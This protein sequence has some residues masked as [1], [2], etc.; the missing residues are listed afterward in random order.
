MKVWHSKELFSRSKIWDDLSDLYENEAEQAWQSVGVPFY[1]TSTPLHAKA[2]AKTT[3]DYFLEQ[4]QKSFSN[5]SSDKFSD[6]SLEWN[7]L[8]WG[9]G[10]G[11]F[12]YLFLKFFEEIFNNYFAGYEQF[13]AVTSIAIPKWRYVMIDISPKLQK[14]WLNHPL[15]KK[16]FS[17]G[18]LDF[19][20]FDLRRDK[21]LFLHQSQQML[22]SERPIKGIVV[23]IANYFFDSLEAEAYIIKNK[24]VF[25][26]L[27][28]AFTQESSPK[29]FSSAVSSMNYHFEAIEEGN[30]FNHAFKQAEG[31]DD[32]FEYYLHH[33]PEDQQFSLPSGASQVCSLIERFTSQGFLLLASDQGFGDLDALEQNLKLELGLHGSIS[34]PVNFHGLSKLLKAQ[35]HSVKLSQ[36]SSHKF[37]TMAA[38]ISKAQEAIGAQNKIQ[39]RLDGFDNENYWRL[40]NQLDLE[41]NQ[42]LSKLYLILKLGDWDPI[43]FF[44]YIDSFEQN[45]SSLDAYEQ[46]RWSQA[47]KKIFDRF[48]PLAPGDLLLIHRLAL[49]AK[50]LN[51]L[52]LAHEAWLLC[53]ELDDHIAIIHFNLAI[54]FYSQQKT[55]LAHFHFKKAEQLDPKLSLS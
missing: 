38:F 5:K 53:L 24:K 46:K 49:L 3:F 41:H 6:E 26:M 23:A 47:L 39:E 44:C 28:E 20:N 15:L 14:L 43:N 40:V 45:I 22:N 32:L 52:T 30:P 51:N 2:I 12:A 29:H 16:Y 4:Y 1:L 25:P 13:S 9:A 33:L 19:A 48:Y 11:R 35:G 18:S 36:N 8:E 50:K 42:N 37:I 27:F 31:I 7:I 55:D 10:A 17:A 54:S 34:F 21:D